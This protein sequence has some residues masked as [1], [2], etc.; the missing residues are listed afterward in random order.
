[1][2]I[3]MT[4]LLW[5]FAFIFLAGGNGF[6]GLFGN[7]R[8]PMGPPPATQEQLT[9]GLNNQSMMSEL[10]ALGLATANNNYETARLIQD[11]NLLMQ[12]QNNTNL[13]NIIQGFNNMM[14]TMQNQTSQLSSKID[15]LGYQMNSYCCEIKTQMLQDRLADKTAEALALQNKLDNRDQTQ[16]ILGNLGRFVAWAGSGA[17]TTTAVGS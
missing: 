16:T 4:N 6:G 3:N 14:M 8:A 1:M 13:V 7:D 5:F 17:P 2:E 15:A 11:Q 10:N 9:L 12:G